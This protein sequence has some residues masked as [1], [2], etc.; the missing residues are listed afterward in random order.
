MAPKLKTLSTDELRV[1][2]WRLLSYEAKTTAKI[3]SNKLKL[4][5]VSILLFERTDNPIY[6]LGTNGD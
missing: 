6:L 1:M 2:R 5:R 3:K 4:V